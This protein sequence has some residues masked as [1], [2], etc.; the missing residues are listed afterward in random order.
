MVKLK[1][2]GFIKGLGNIIESE[3]E[4]YDELLELSENNAELISPRDEIYARKDRKITFIPCRGV[5]HP[6]W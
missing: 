2:I 6:P 5:N 1:P 3:R 4:F